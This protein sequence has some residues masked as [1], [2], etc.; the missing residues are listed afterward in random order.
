VEIKIVS[1]ESVLHYQWAKSFA[2]YYVSSVQLL[3][4]RTLG[5]VFVFTLIGMF[6]VL[7]LSIEKNAS[8]FLE[9]TIL[10]FVSS[11]DFPWH[12]VEHSFMSILQFPYRILPFAILFLTLATV[13]GVNDITSDSVTKEKGYTKIESGYSVN[14]DHNGNND[15]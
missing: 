2:G 5:F 12:M 11:S 9:G 8:L 10:I 3:S 14:Y 1:P 13:S 4:T 15:C 7:G 6:T